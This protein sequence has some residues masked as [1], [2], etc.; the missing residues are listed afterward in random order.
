MKN[1][2][3]L[4][5]TTNQSYGINLK[6]LK[7]SELAKSFREIS[8]ESENKEHD[9]SFLY[10]RESDRIGEGVPVSKSP[11]S[12]QLKTN[13][14]KKKRFHDENGHDSTVRNIERDE[15]KNRQDFQNYR[16]NPVKQN[17]LFTTTSNDIGLVKPVEQLFT[18]VRFA[19]NQ[20]FSSQF[21]GIMYRDEG[22][23]SK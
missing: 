19:R 17:P 16:H 7:T 15:Y 1:C 9:L 8:N 21:N 2:K 22:L 20:S 18:H 14:R 23:R 10:T 5:L 11:L 4:M 12:K 3:D 6:K 13:F